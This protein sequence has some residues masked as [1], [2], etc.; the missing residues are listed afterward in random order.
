L[1]IIAVQIFVVELL[2]QD[3]LVNPGRLLLVGGLC[4][5]LSKQQKRKMLYLENELMIEKERSISIK[6]ISMVH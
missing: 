2:C 1:S 4:P 5:P 3:L 6:F